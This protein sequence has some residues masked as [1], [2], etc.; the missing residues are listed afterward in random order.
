M[1]KTRSRVGEHFKSEIMKR[2]KLNFGALALVLGLALAFTG[3]A[4]KSSATNATRYYTPSGSGW[5]D[6]TDHVL[7]ENYQC[8]DTSPDDCLV[9]FSNDDPQTGTKIVLEEGEFEVINP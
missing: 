8:N 6:I 2:F 9:Q 1:P 4:F 3:S 7:E 5:M